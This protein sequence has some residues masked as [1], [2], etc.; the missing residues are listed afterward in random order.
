MVQEERAQSLAFRFDNEEILLEHAAK[1]P[2]FG[3][4]FW[5][6]NRVRDPETGR[7]LTVT[8][9]YWIIIIG[10]LG[11]TGYISVFG[12][13]TLPLF[14]LWWCHNATATDEHRLTLG[15]SLLLAVNLLELIPNSSINTMTWLLVGLLLASSLETAKADN[16]EN[17]TENNSIEAKNRAPYS[18]QHSRQQP[19]SRDHLEKYSREKP[20]SSRLIR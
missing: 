4:G 13:L 17:T 20:V 10:V 2:I 12:L 11:W 7:S 9:G 5:D 1:R 3:W 18:R 8:D 14:R 6:R 16:D 15:T 19:Y